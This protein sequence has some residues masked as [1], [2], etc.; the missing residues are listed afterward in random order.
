[1]GEWELQLSFYRYCSVECIA[2]IIIIII[3]FIV[4]IIISRLKLIGKQDKR[5]S[6]TSEYV[7]VCV[8]V[9]V[10]VLE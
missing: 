3:I 2:I 6:Y 7:C 4:N 9:C 5:K 1:M 10:C 8:C